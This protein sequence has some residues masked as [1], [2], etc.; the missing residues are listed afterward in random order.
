MAQS[1][2]SYARETGALTLPDEGRIALFEP[3]ADMLGDD[4]PRERCEVI[5]R[6]ATTD[7]ALSSRGFATSRRPSGPYAAALVTLPRARA[8]A[9]QLLAEAE[10]AA[11]GGL[12]VVDGAKTDGFDAT[13]KALKKRLSLAGTVSKAHGK[14]AW[15]EAADA[16]SDWLRPERQRIEG[17]FATAPGV[18]SA[19]GVDPASE[20]LAE[21]LPDHVGDLVADLGAGWGY[22]SSRLLKDPA[23]TRLFLVEND[24]V[25]LDCAKDTLDDPRAEYHWADATRWTAPAP[26]DAVVMNPPFHQGRAADPGLGR[27]FIEAA[28]RMLAPHGRVWLVANRHLPYEDVLDQCFG[29]HEETG[30]DRRFKIL[31]ASRPRRRR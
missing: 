16:L 13:L 6:Y 7:Q 15:F 14:I 12:V 5:T 25:A 23:L 21:A 27:A 17:G 2:L 29:Q 9:E 8:L 22:L 20:A 30:G 10:A 3:P 11:P 24:A 4:L 1:R 28:A 18:F 26:L 31:S 19:D